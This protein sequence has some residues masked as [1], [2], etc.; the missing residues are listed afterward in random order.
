[1]KLKTNKFI[2]R[3]FDDDLSNEELELFREK[4]QTDIKFKEQVQL[5]EQ[6]FGDLVYKR[7]Q[8]MKNN[9]IDLE[10]HTRKS[11]KVI[12]F[13]GIMKRVIMFPL[14]FVVIVVVFGLNYFSFSSEQDFRLIFEEYFE[15]YPNI[16]APISRSSEYLDSELS[17]VMILYETGQYEDALLG[18]N[19]LIDGSNAY[20]NELLFYKGL[21]LLA[22]DNSSEAVSSFELMDLSSDMEN[23]RKWYLSLALGQS[24]EL[25]QAKRLLKDIESDSSHFMIYASDLLDELQ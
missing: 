7:E 24:G 23:Q 1:L 16:L 10:L 15:P 19:T 21:S 25:T 6:V 20:H 13:N 2:E 11:K 8:K 3:Y 4:I 14:L 9:F 18:L 12:F 17:N 5:Y 22:S